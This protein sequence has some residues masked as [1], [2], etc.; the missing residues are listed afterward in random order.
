MSLES[1]KCETTPTGPF[2]SFLGAFLVEMK[3]KGGGR[4][5]TRNKGGQ[6]KRRHP[7]W[8]QNPN[9]KGK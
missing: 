5:R 8:I 7:S 6:K 2:A 9:K 3:A 4:G 1:G